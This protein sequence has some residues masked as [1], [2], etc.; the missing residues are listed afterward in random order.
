M[1]AHNITMLQGFK[2]LSTFIIIAVG[3]SFFMFVQY[4]TSRA[5]RLVFSIPICPSWKRLTMNYC[6]EEGI[7]ILWLFRSTPFTKDFEHVTALVKVYS[8]F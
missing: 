2:L 4:M 7:I 3:I 8:L 5:V 6:I 1:D